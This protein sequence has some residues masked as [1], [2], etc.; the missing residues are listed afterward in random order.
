MK[1]TLKFLDGAGNK[2]NVTVSIFYLASNGNDVTVTFCGNDAHLYK[3][4]WQGQFHSGDRILELKWAVKN[5]TSKGSWN[6]IV[7]KLYDYHLKT[8]SELKK[9][10]YVS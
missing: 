7:P 8:N 5:P 4:E 10:T 1:E 3:L 6:S 2:N 9:D